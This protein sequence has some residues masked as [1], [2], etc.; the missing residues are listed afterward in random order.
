MSPEDEKTTAGT[1]AE[2]KAENAVPEQQRKLFIGGLNF[3]TNNED[4]RHYFSKFGDV[5]DSIIM[6]DKATG[7]SRG[8]GFIVYSHI[9]MVDEV[10]E[11]RPHTLDGRTIS[12]KRAVSKEETEKNNGALS[13]V[14]KIFV[15]GIKE[16]TEEEHIRDVFKNF[17]E[18]ESIEVLTDRD[19]QK[20]RGF[21]FVTFL[22]HDV[23]DKI[24]TLKTHT[25]NGHSC[26][27]KKAIPKTEIKKFKS[28]DGRRDHREY[29][30]S[31]PPRDYER[32]GPPRSA[33]DR[34]APPS[35]YEPSSRYGDERKPHYESRYP[36]HP[37]DYDRYRDYYRDHP[38][39]ADYRPPTDYYRREDNDRCYLKSPL[40]NSQTSDDSLYCSD[41]DKYRLRRPH[42]NKYLDLDHRLLDDYLVNASSPDTSPD[43]K[44]RNSYDR[45]P[46]DRY[47]YER[48]AYDERRPHER[49][50]RAYP[51]YERSPPSHYRRSPPPMSRGSPPTESRYPA[52]DYYKGAK[53]GVYGDMYKREESS[54]GPAK[55]NKHA[56]RSAAPYERA[57]SP[58]AAKYSPPKEKPH[59]LSRYY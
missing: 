36:P 53:P 52:D 25:I 56:A 19:T 23:V 49:D 50:A 9:S 45:P 54:F 12:P 35:R 20:K 37:S 16:D 47:A 6:T 5:T 3:D 57:K 15:G 10:M 44:R 46:Y 31:P 32:Y 8:F 1:P 41:S 34:Y 58:G 33:Y 22:D 29:R 43:L 26:E 48:P 11:K 42:R 2:T 17:G 38:R 7:K 21:A 18:I 51:P 24:V 14:K 27:V 13:Q 30:R 59:Q 40:S 4:F 39:Y 55:S 28:D